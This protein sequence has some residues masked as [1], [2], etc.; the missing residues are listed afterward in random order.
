MRKIASPQEL[1]SELRSL[2]TFIQGSEQPSR[3]V[4]ARKLRD[5]ADRLA[6]SPEAE[7]E[8]MQAISDRM[9]L[10]ERKPRAWYVLMGKA[11]A[12]AF[13]G[14]VSKVSPKAV[15]VTTKNYDL[16]VQRDQSRLYFRAY[17]PGV[18]PRTEWN[19]VGAVNADFNDAPLYSLDPDDRLVAV[20]QKFKKELPKSVR[21]Q[22]KHNPDRFE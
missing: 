22:Q 18:S 15:V 3:E 4:I 21:W 5:L 20:S 12:A 16:V 8:R 9:V 6:A 14:Q 7:K 1:G 17:L 10:F 11:L 19:Y 2:E 13:R